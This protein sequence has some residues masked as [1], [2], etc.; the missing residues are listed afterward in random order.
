M[1]KRYIPKANDRFRAFYNGNVAY[2]AADCVCTGRHYTSNRL[3]YLEAVDEYGI[4]RKFHPLR[5]STYRYNY[6]Y[7]P[8]KFVGKSKKAPKRKISGLQD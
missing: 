2:N 6:C 8:F 7:G 3:A 1:V 5:C 4:E